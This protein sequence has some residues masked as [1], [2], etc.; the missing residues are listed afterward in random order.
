LGNGINGCIDDLRIYNRALTVSEIKSLYKDKIPAGVSPS[1]E[2][3]APSTIRVNEDTQITVR[4]L[5]ELGNLVS[6]SDDKVKLSCKCG[7]VVPASFYLHSGVATVNI[8]FYQPF[9]GCQ[10][11]AD[12]NGVS[13]ETSNFIDIVGDET[14]YAS[15]SGRVI[16]S[17]GQ[18]IAGAKVYLTN[19]SKL[20]TKQT[21]SNSDGNYFFDSM[22]P[23]FYYVWAEVDGITRLLSLKAGFNLNTGP[24]VGI[25]IKIRDKKPPV[26]LVPAF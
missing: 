18:A 8:R 3:T 25:D 12:S 1:L 13:G 19:V 23:G 26:L 22:L 6:N 14:K 7:Y 2:I 24:N 5:D 17:I 4:M 16:D 21:Y 10:L 9:Y 20:S 15:L 11:C